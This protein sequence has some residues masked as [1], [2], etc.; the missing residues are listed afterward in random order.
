MPVS[1][2][3]MAA[4]R[5][6][7]KQSDIFVLCAAAAP[8]RATQAAGILAAHFRRVATSTICRKRIFWLAVFA[9]PADWSGYQPERQ[10]TAQVRTFT[11]AFLVKSSYCQHLRRFPN[12]FVRTA[13][14]TWWN[15]PFKNLA[16]QFR[17]AANLYFLLISVLQVRSL[18]VL[19]DTG[20]VRACRAPRKHRSCVYRAGFDGFVADKSVLNASSIDWCAVC[21]YDQV[22]NR[23]LQASHSRLRYQQ[24]QSK[25]LAH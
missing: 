19:C 21:V 2:S 10:Q 24:R 18:K 25:G 14:Y 9:T 8:S 23:G 20:L 17:R 5:N 22:G 16:E 13:R 7:C 1:E 12:N 11:C 15:F 4:N 3:Q 6:I